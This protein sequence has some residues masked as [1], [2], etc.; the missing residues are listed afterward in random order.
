MSITE[1]IA[2]GAAT[3]T[4]VAAIT[5]YCSDD[6]KINQKIKI[7]CQGCLLI[8]G[9]AMAYDLSSKGYSYIKQI[10][11]SHNPWTDPN[12][13]SKMG[14]TVPDAVHPPGPVSAQALELNKDC[15]SALGTVLERKLPTDPHPTPQ[16]L[17]RL[18]TLSRQPGQTSKTIIATL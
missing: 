2:A 1:N 14:S 5:A 11:L 8:F 10:K 4:V 18:D 7:V 12:G 17:Q 6:E 15:Q 13:M 9:I 16:A 3:V